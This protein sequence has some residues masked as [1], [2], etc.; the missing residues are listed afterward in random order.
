MDEERLR[1][2]GK[3][4]EFRCLRFATVRE[5]WPALLRAYEQKKA[6]AAER[7]AEMEAR[8]YV[9]F[10][11]L[12]PLTKTCLAC[13]LTW[14]RS[15]LRSTLYS[16]QRSTK[17]NC[18]RLLLAQLHVDLSGASETYRAMSVGSIARHL[19]HRMRLQSFVH[20]QGCKGGQAGATA[21][22]G[23]EQGACRNGRQDA[24]VPAA[25][26]QAAVAG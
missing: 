15:V 18:L 19:H 5:C 25:A 12:H 16:R 22:G 10:P 1:E 14:A 20:A 6:D 17:M 2:K 13:L 23:A 7:A 21:S 3:S 11:P 8:K 26:T 9:S 4:V 24:E